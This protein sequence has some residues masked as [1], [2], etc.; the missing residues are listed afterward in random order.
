MAG[1]VTVALALAIGPGSEDINNTYVVAS[2][3]MPFLWVLV[4]GLARAYEHRYLGVSEEEYRAVGRAV[5]GLLSLLAIGGLFVKAQW[6]RLYVITLVVM[7]FA[8]GLLVRRAMR[9]WLHAH[10]RQGQL[11][12]R[13]VVV[14][15]ADAAAEL[16]RNIKRSPD[17]GLD[18]VAVCTS[19]LDSDWNTTSSIE[20]VPVMGTALDAISA[21]DL[22]DA[23][24]VAVTSHPELAG[25]G[26]RRLA[27]ALEER[28][29]ELV[30]STG[31]L[32][33]AGPRLSLRQSTDMSLLHIERPAATRRSVVLKSLMDRTLAAALVLMLSPVFIGIALAIKFTSPGPVLFR[34][35]RVGV[36]GEFFTIYKFRT[37]VVD[38]EKQL[39]ALMQYNE[40]NT[41]QFKMKKDPRITPIGTFLRRFSLDELPQL[42]NVLIGNMSLVGPRPQSQAEVEQYEPDAMRRLHVRPGMTGLW[43]ISGRSDLDWEQSIRLDL[44]YV[45]NWSPIVDLQILFRTFKAVVT[46]NGA[47]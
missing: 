45:D 1:F 34:Q 3:V 33:V 8:L 25:K 4:L 30:V 28:G 5:L 20:G 21:V 16:I 18:V 29:V 40:G 2:L 23:E 22:V 7:L 19:G 32:D 47:Y 24:V 41:V 38:A 31:L 44:R 17:Q 46:S 13:T 43:Q 39:A 26:L 27:W 15:R 14:G 35:K 6:S 9:H 36:G 10:R 12:Q 42:F 37:M 11:M